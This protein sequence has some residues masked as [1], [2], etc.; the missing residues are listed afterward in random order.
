MTKPLQDVGDSSIKK[1]VI[2]V[3][4]DKKEKDS[5]KKKEKKIAKV[6]KKEIKKAEIK[7]VKPKRSG[8]ND[9]GSK[10][11]REQRNSQPDGKGIAKSV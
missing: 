4:N 2:T 3:Q 10:N 9:A 8:A 11:K 1:T 5:S 6:V 7:K